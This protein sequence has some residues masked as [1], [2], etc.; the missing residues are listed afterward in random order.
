MNIQYYYYKTTIDVIVETE[1]GSHFEKKLN[2][3]IERTC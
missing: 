3:K 2:V 1:D